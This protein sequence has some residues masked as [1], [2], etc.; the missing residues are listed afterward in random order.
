MLREG[1]T[2]PA[3]VYNKTPRILRGYYDKIRTP[4]YSER[5]LAMLQRF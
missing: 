5:S 2:F 3:R 1:Q 4:V